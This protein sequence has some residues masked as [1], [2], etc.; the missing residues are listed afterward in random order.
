MKK[1]RDLRLLSCLK[2][3][4]KE[5][6][7]H[8]NSPDPEKSVESGNEPEP[9]GSQVGRKGILF[10]YCSQYLGLIYIIFR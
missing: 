10:I 2:N 3:N 8:T 9:N 5:V 4:N 7:A 1:Y 6:T